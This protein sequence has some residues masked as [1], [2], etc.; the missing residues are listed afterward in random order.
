MGVGRHFFKSW[1]GERKESKN[2]GKKDRQ[3]NNLMNKER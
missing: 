2:E 3:K 1:T